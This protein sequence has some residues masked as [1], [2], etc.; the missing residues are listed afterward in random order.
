M[1][2]H[3]RITPDVIERT[4]CRCYEKFL[5]VRNLNGNNARVCDDCKEKAHVAAYAERRNGVRI[6]AGAAEEL[7]RERAAIDE[8]NRTRPAVTVPE[9]LQQIAR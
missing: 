6:R 1:P 5:T 4:Y 2:V 9:A 3:H 8:L 7:A